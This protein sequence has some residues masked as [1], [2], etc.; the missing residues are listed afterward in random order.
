MPT[1][2]ERVKYAIDHMDRGETYAALEH[3]CNA[4]DVT[5]QRYYGQKKSSRSYFKNIIKEYSWLIEFMSL[6]G[7]NLDETT[8]DNFPIIEGVRQPILKPDFSDLMYHVVRCGLVH[9]DSLSDGFSFH[10]EA[11][12]LLAENTIIFPESVVW[13]ILSI[14]IFCPINKDQTTA[15]GYWIGSFENRLVINDF[16]GN[17]GIAHH[18]ANRYPRPRVTLADLSKL[19]NDQ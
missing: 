8:F 7:I 6:G 1:I 17:E 15:P 4:L 18:L 9:S 12:L 13:G 19:K 5:S 16:W 2:G 11:T 3:A 14:T 10:K